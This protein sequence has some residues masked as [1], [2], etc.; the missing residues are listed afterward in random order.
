MY[1]MLCYNGLSK[2]KVKDYQ[3]VTQCCIK[4]SERFG[5]TDRC[6]FLSNAKLDQSFDSAV[7]NCFKQQHQE[8]KSMILKLLN[9]G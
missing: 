6:R 5:K 1:R 9:T 4:K 7:V 3:P 8:K 2:Q